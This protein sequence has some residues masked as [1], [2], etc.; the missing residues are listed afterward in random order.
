MA[1]PSDTTGKISAAVIEGWH[2]FEVPKWIELWRSFED[3]DPYPQVIDNWAVDVGQ[4][5]TDYDVL[6]FYNMNQTIDESPFSEQLQ[7][8]LDALGDAPQGIVM[9]HHAILAYPQYEKWSDIVG[10]GKRDFGF[11]PDQDYVVN[12]ANPD[13]P[14]TQGMG[15][16]SIHDE[17]Y[18]MPSPAPGDADIL[19][20]TEYEQSMDVL[21]WTRTYK[22]SRVFCFQPGHDHATWDD[23]TFREYLRRGMLWSAG[24]LG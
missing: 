8:A 3:I 4:C 16:W 2:P 22:N 19:M 12:V 13:H 15:A 6:V 23:P 18:T 17:T 20:T 24:Q 11:H 7:G 5:R 9:L 1:N 10:V 21:A 14:I